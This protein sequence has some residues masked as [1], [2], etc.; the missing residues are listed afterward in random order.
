[1]STTNLEIAKA[2][3]A[4]FN[5][6]SAEPDQFKHFLSPAV[7]YEE[8]PN[9]LSPDDSTRGLDQMLDGVEQ[10]RRLLSEQDYQ[11]LRAVSEG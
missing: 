5:D 6:P 3:I 4:F 9:L 2:Y 10:V 11:I 7:V 1:M 8:M